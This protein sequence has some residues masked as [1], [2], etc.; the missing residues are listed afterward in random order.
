[1]LKKLLFK[2][3]PN[4]IN[5]IIHEAEIIA[6]YG[7]MDR[8]YDAMDEHAKNAQEEQE[9][10]DMMQAEQEQ[11]YLMSQALEEEAHNEEL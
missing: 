3:F 10:Y 4:T 5:E 6:N 8:Y 11:E 9:Y 1:M 7:S 2:L